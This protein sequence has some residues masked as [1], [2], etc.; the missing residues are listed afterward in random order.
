MVIYT[1]HIYTWN[2]L[3]LTFEGIAL[4]YNRV[5]THSKEPQKLLNV[6]LF[7]KRLE[8][9]LCFSI[10]NH[11]NH[12]TFLTHMNQETQIKDPFDPILDLV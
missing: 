10:W 5:K 9:Y 12:C 4:C 11:G 3:H 6:I 2:Q 1:Q 8:I 7:H